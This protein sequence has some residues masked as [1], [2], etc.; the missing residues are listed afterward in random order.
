MADFRFVIDDRYVN[1][2]GQVLY[3]LVE[4]DDLNNGSTPESVLSLATAW[5]PSFLYSFFVND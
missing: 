3:P 1:R 2:I 4:P 5:P